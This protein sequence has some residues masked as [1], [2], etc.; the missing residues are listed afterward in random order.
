MKAGFHGETPDLSKK[1]AV[2]CLQFVS[3]EMTLQR[4]KG[5]TLHKKQMII[6]KSNALGQDDTAVLM[7]LRLKLKSRMFQC[8]CFNPSR[9]KSIKLL[10]SLH[11]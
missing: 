8:I 1:Q 10:Q 4:E 3:T 11:F 7:A 2:Y 5:Q 6:S 9:E